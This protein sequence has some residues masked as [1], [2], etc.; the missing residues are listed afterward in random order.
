MSESLRTALLRD[1]PGRA[2]TPVPGP[3]PGRWPTAVSLAAAPPLLL[4][5][6][7][8][9]APHHF[10]FPDQIAAYSSAP[11]QMTWGTGSG[12]P[13][14]CSWCPPSPDWPPRSPGPG[15]CWAPPRGSC[16]CSA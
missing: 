8:A 15:P 1:L 14:C 13:G 4:A 11:G 7:L 16:A 3:F 5:G 6:E 9:K 2:E 12:S 10:F